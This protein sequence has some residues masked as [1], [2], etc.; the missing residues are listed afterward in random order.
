MK[1]RC[2]VTADSESGLALTEQEL[3]S[4]F[5][6]VPSASYGSIK[7]Q[8]STTKPSPEGGAGD[9]IFTSTRSGACI[10]KTTT[11]WMHYPFSA[12]ASLFDMF[13]SEL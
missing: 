9:L 5:T 2:C 4:P 13:C 11:V 10:C 12:P 1:A 6:V 3:T 8:E 7:N